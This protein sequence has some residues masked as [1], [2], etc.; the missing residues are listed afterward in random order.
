MQFRGDRISVLVGIFIGGNVCVR[1]N[2]LRVKE[3]MISIVSQYFSL[4]SSIFSHKMS[5]TEVT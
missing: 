3:N 4:E 2:N 5:S 1:G